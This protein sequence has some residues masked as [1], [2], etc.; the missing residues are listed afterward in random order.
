[1]ELTRSDT[2]LSFGFGL[3]S[4]TNGEKIITQVSENSPA[5]GELMT[6]D[7]IVMID[8]RS[9]DEFTHDEAIS[10]MC[11][12]TIVK[13][14]VERRHD[15][16]GQARRGSISTVAPEIRMQQRRDS[17]GKTVV[18]PA[19]VPQHISVDINRSSVSQS[20]GFGVGTSSSNDK[21]V[22]KIS[23]GG[24]AVGKLEAGDIIKTING[25]DADTLTHEQTIA[26]MVSGLQLGLVVERR[27]DE[28]E[29]QKREPQ[30][31]M[32]KRRDSIGKVVNVPA[33]VPQHVEVELHR[34]DA[35][36]SF[37]FGL[38]SSATGDKVVTKVS[39]GGVA[40]G[41][42]ATADLIMTINGIDA[43]QLSHEEAI[44]EMVSSNT[45][46]LGVERRMGADGIQRRGSISTEEP[47][48]RMLKRRDSIGK[49]V[50]VPAGVPQH[51]AVELHRT[52]ASQSFGFGLGSSATGDKVVTKVSEGGVAVGKLATADLIMTING[53]DAKELSHEEAIAEMVSSN[54]LRLGVVRRMGADGIQRRGSISTEEPQQR[55]LKRRDSIGKVVNVPAGVPQHVAVELHRTDASQS[56]GFGLGSSATGDKVVTKV[57]EG[58]VAVGKLA[59]A[60]LIMTINGIDA[61]KLS[62]EEAIAEM[63]SSNTLRLGVERR[64]GADGIQRRGSISTEEPQQRMLKRRDS[65]GKVVNVPA[66]VPQHV[67]VEV[68]RTDASQS[69]GFGLGSSATGDKVVTKVS[70]GGV[71][72]GKLATA[73][74]IM[75]INGIDA[76][77]LSHEEAIA[78]MVSSNTLRLGVERRMGADGIQRRGSISTEE[79]QQRMLK[80]RDSIGKVV[81]V[82]AGVPQHVAV[83]LHRTDASQ[84]FGFGLG[85]SATGDKVV[86]KVSE[87][88]VAVG[89]LATADLIMT[90]NGIDAKEL[91]HEEAINE[92]VSGYTLRLGVERRMGADGIQRR[93]SISTEEPQQRMLKRRD[94]IGKV[95]NVPAGVP[96][97]VEVEVH[98]T[99]ASQ[100]FGFG[101][102]SSATG[103]KV[104][105]KV[106]EGGVAVGKLA[107]ADLIMTINGIDAK[108]L[109]HEEAIAE[110]VSSNTL[111]LGVERRMG[112][113]GIQRR[114]SISTE[115][116]QQRM[117][118]RRDSIGKVVNVPAGVPQHVAVELHRTDASQSFGFGL[119]SSATGD[120]VVTKVSEGGVAVG[121][122]ATADLIMTINGIDAKEL[123]HEE[124]I[125]EMVS[126][127]TLRLGVERRMGADGIQRR[128][129]IST[130]EPQQRMLKRRDSIGKVVNVPA[131]VPQHVEVEVHRTD[132]SQ[133][134]GFG[135]GSSATGDKVVTKV[136]EG[137]VAV[138]KLATADLI[139][140]I[141]GI[142]AKQLS[143]EE[144]IAEMVS[145]NTLRL[146]V[147]RRMGADGIQRRGSIS[148][149]EPQQRMLKRRD[150]IGKV[151]NVP[152]GVP[153]HVAVELHRTDTS[154]SFGFGL[155]SSPDGQKVITKVT[156]GGVAVGKLMEADLILTINGIDAKNLSHDKS[157]AE[158]VSAVTLRLGV[159]RRINS[160]PQG[161]DVADVL[162]QESVGKVVSVPEGVP[163]HLTVDLYR[164]SMEQS[165]G[166]G[167]G[168]S[169]TGE[170]IVTKVTEG[171]VAEGRLE[172][173]DLIKM[174]NGL[175]AE[176]LSHDDAI[177][178]MC[179]G[180]S[181]SIG[182][183][184]R[185]SAEG[186]HRRGSISVA[187]PK[188]NVLQR[189]DSIGKVVSLPGGV[190]QH[191]TI[192]LTRFSP[193]QSFGFGL[194]SSSTG[195]KI[196][197]KISEGGIAQG[198]LETADLV[199]M[200]N[201]LNATDLSHEDAIAEMCSGTTVSLGIERRVP[202]DGSA[203]RGSITTASPETRVVKRRDSIGSSIVSVP[204]GHPH[205]VT[206]EI[207]RT[208]ANQSFGFGLGSSASG[209]KVV[210]KISEGGLAEGKLETADIVNSINGTTA[211]DLN[212][213]DAVAEMCSSTTLVLTVERRVGTDGVRRKGSI[214]TV[215]P[216]MQVLKRRDSIGSSIVSV[217]GG[218]PH[219]VT[220]EITRT[221]ANQ[222]F[223]FGLGSSASGDKVVTKISEGGLAEGKLE[224]ADIVNSINGTT[225]R[226]LNHEDAVA[227][228][229]SS[230]TLVLTVER[231][232]GTD[233]VRRK[234]SITTVSPEMQ[235]LKR[236]DSIGSSI[237][238]VPGGHPH[239]VTVEITRTSANQ[240]FGFG[241]GSSASGDKVVTKISEG[242][243]AEGKLE[244]ADIVNSINGTTAR[245]LNHEDAVAEM[246]SSTTLVLTVERRVGTDGVR[247]KGSITTVS[248]EMQV[249]KRRDSIGSDVM[250][251]PFVTRRHV[252]EVQREA[253]DQGFG[254]GMGTAKDGN[255][256][257][258]SV[259][260]KGSVMA[261]I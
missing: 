75:T 237:V 219:V 152:A 239:V 163:Q 101:L 162:R 3:G 158:M 109:S 243:L 60:D 140:T 117:L 153:Q 166:F 110:M 130:E 83:E 9:A 122:L 160:A 248:P 207:T 63:V 251:H 104:V 205:V 33:G 211:R 186:T 28:D 143:H 93:G 204:G 157:I 183:E 230:T 95:V 102:G 246:C 154:Q 21:V 167:L 137:G 64:M 62:H 100:S 197:T 40:V 133:S 184:R 26:E 17:I 253:L 103:D 34:T 252:V 206:V 70:E 67:E 236:R 124:A 149:E 30:Q 2:G 37:G 1:M 224:T 106:S 255:K 61:K 155:G 116:P 227:E 74:L 176:D 228:M 6:A 115:E 12:G 182:I 123:S 141:N 220:V 78:E 120:K 168:S 180:T 258:S 181:L 107:T 24:I 226:D 82:P 135:L 165:F 259:N 261:D 187:S 52:D 96:Q 54:T 50:T 41:K 169:S 20:F 195:D 142:D 139:M 92:M 250:Q 5:D 156:E 66:G 125:N 73:D 192:E 38:G 232:V 257:V 175:N 7:L 185:F 138:G 128:G 178:E 39:E 80:R 35:S 47:Q 241:L 72:V 249:L 119:G 212:H 32:L 45:L 222:S 48:Q 23:E 18:V 136:S 150:S 84:S 209:D 49:V 203:R 42:L 129:S 118:K 46:R 31:R 13:L 94:S 57:S 208:S 87:G 77:Q 145:S 244:T 148:T 170:K 99:D 159:E 43:K 131:G 218:H 56:F 223:G 231:R 177:V 90:I 88:G 190:P 172:T 58:G 86:T 71:A 68:H 179:S 44:A 65:I 132:A 112:A 238:S 85:S 240:S 25:I 14:R 147:E 113:D 16:R 196:I 247:R 221:S 235:V 214:T 254:F 199:K 55:M 53:I 201:G 215:S 174:I 144:A 126:G 36:Q 8:G 189:R 245:D 51:V 69:F 10:E 161:S 256:L 193:D 11:R 22:M 233:G 105:T 4:S 225:A 121:K 91:S 171:G 127:Y 217:P 81:N 79:P 164:D 111:R 19:G 202:V 97:H 194:G 59:T 216:E 229:C 29:S 108:Q 234:G 260:P 191:Y 15:N 200:I 151:V 210:T 146:G 98:R 27:L 213:E 76:K 89:K 134:F 188:T 198:K 114:G 173:T 242:G